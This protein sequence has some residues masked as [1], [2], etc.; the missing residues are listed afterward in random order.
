MLNESDW[1][2]RMIVVVRK[3]REGIYRKYDIG[4]DIFNRIRC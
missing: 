4:V 3:K 2:T 1:G